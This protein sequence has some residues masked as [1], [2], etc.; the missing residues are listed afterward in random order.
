MAKRVVVRRKKSNDAMKAMAGSCIGDWQII[1]W[2]PLLKDRVVC[3]C[4]CGNV[5]DSVFW[6]NL[7][8]GRSNGCGCRK[9]ER[10]ASKKIT[11]GLSKTREYRIWASMISRC[12]KLSDKKARYFDRGISVC[13]GFREFQH[14]LLVIGPIT[15]GMSSID[16]KNNNLSYSCGKC[17]ECLS[18]GWPMNCRWANP[19]IQSNNRGD[20][21]KRYELNGEKL[22][23]PEWSAKIGVDKRV[24]YNRVLNLGWDFKKSINTPVVSRKNK[25]A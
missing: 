11:H 17:A 23:I 10:I 25:A 14:F 2:N 6:S 13:A 3:K 18:K 22:T 15:S 12:S 5:V 9:K 8:R 7:I 4:A 21:I 16:R 19:T 1:G 20:F 24:I